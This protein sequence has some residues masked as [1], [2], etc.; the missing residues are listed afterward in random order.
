MGFARRCGAA[1]DARP[2]GGELD[3]VAVLVDHAESDVPQG[4]CQ[5]SGAEQLRGRGVDEC[6]VEG[7][8]ESFRGLSCKAATAGGLVARDTDEVADQVVALPGE[9]ASSGA[10]G[11]QVGLVQL[12]AEL[13]Q[14]VDA[15]GIGADELVGEPGRHRRPAQGRYG[16]GSLVVAGIAGR[17]G[18][19]VPGADELL[20]YQPVQLDNRGVGGHLSTMR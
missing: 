2:D 11:R 9:F 8:G 13:G 1:Y 4:A 7:F 20:G 6:G 10:V 14:G 17:L 16:S 15:V 3:R 19:L 5:L 12:F 18:Q